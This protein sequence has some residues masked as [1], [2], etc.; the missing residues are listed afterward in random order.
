M[1]TF[2]KINLFCCI[3]IFYTAKI[4]AQT[5]PSI[6]VEN[7]S[8]SSGNYNYC[9]YGCIISPFN[10][11]QTVSITNTAKVVYRAGSC[12]QLLPGFSVSALAPS[13]S[14]GGSFN[15]Q[16]AP[17]DFPVAVITPTTSPTT[18][19]GLFEKLEYGLDLPSDID[20]LVTAYFTN[21]SDPTA[22]N[23][24][25]PEDIT[26]DAY[27]VSPSGTKNR[28]I[29]GFY[30][31]A[32]DYD[33]GQPQLWVD[34]P[35]P[36]NFRVRFAP[37]ELGQWGCYIEV[38]SPSGKFP[39]YS[40]NCIQFESVPS[41]NKG[42]LEV[43]LHKRQLKFS[44][45]GES[46]FAIGQ[47][48][49]WIHNPY[50]GTNKFDANS[51]NEYY[52]Q[53]Q[54][55]ADNDGNFVRMIM[56]PWSHGIEFEKLGN[57]GKT[58]QNTHPLAHSPNENRQHNAFELDKIFDLCE[59]RDVYMMLDLEM[60]SNY[61]A[62]GDG[63]IAPTYLWGNFC[64]NTP[65]GLGSPL[66][67]LTDL[68][69][70]KYFKRRLRY[71]IARWG[72]STSLGVIELLSEQ[73]GW[74]DYC[75]RASTDDP[76]TPLST[77]MAA[78]ADWNDEMSKYIKLNT[79]LGDKNHLITTSFA[80]RPPVPSPFSSSWI[81]LTSTHKY[82]RDKDINHTR[83]KYMNDNTGSIKGLLVDYDKPSIFGELGLLT[84]GDV[85]ESDVGDVEG[86]DDV[87]FHNSMWST[88]FMGCYGVGLNWW[89]EYNANYRQDNYPPLKAFF[90]GIDFEAD[91][92][93]Y[94]E[95]WKRFTLPLVN[96]KAETFWI[97][98]FDKSKVMG[99]AHEATYY[100][101]NMVSTCMTSLPGTPWVLSSPPTIPS[102]D[103]TYPGPVGYFAKV[104]VDNLAIGTAYNLDWYYTRDY[105][106]GYYFTSDYVL[107]GLAGIIK[108]DYPAA[109]FKDFA[110]KAVQDP[111]F[112]LGSGT[113]HEMA[114][115]SL[116]CDQDTLY[117]G[118]TYKGDI[119]GVYSYNWN[120][121]NGQT[122][123]LVH[124]TAVYSQPG[125]YTA[126]LIVTDTNQF[127][128]T[129]V[130]K[131][132]VSNCGE[133]EDRSF[134]L[135]GNS[136]SPSS[137]ISVY[138]NPNN[139]KFTI[140]FTEGNKNVYKIEIFDCIGKLVF[141]EE[142][143]VSKKDINIVGERK[144]MYLLKISSGNDVLIKKIVVQ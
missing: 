17:P 142:N 19:V 139:G 31:E 93:A 20:N 35:T 128:D 33:G 100:W 59:Q 134:I 49:N 21:N 88:A 101:Y 65:L 5:T 55:L 141:M 109:T 3:L 124:P 90:S 114:M 29:Y 94:P 22:V 7:I 54:N 64:Y 36:Y 16:L 72:Y 117:F 66:D 78:S 27:F 108:P 34:Q 102:E 25:N 61:D 76:C 120:F 24:F 95:R 45:T 96:Y 89:Q 68:D 77:T 104:Q 8:P 144:G 133:E 62:I 56:A 63:S 110:F 107:S 13:G 111:I 123:T 136:S 91:K 42:Y 12:I 85:G 9:S 80:D 6:V 11:S 129:L 30:Y 50:W 116:F 126:T 122:S 113:Y 38:S 137:Y 82:G 57:Y 118:G 130:Q 138:P 51:F 143:V 2:F 40:A 1:K 23:P 47:N 58:D 48:I 15:T 103:D 131:F 32:F 140:D 70:K 112:S 84:P 121:G 86:C 26:I 71:M 127:I 105:G 75:N 28:K 37:T 92:F 43:G 41:T 4:S 115:D 119:N 53:V 74:D 106:S 97:R 79:G 39:S 52:N 60:Q 132:F 135:I 69:A 10:P 87:S 125:I 73:E 46:F 14:G 44:G 67:A 98:N 81:D 99:W 18:Q 83:Y